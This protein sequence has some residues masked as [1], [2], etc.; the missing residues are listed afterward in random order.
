MCDTDILSLQ[1]W[2]HLYFIR[3]EETSCHCSAVSVRCWFQNTFISCCVWYKEW[4]ESGECALIWELRGALYLHPPWCFICC[5]TL[6]VYLSLTRLR[7]WSWLE[8]TLLSGSHTRTLD[9]ALSL[10]LF[11]CLS[12]YLKLFFPTFSSPSCTLCLHLIPPLSLSPPFFHCH[13]LSVFLSLTLGW[14]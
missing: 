8:L 11:M 12:C 10:S 14:Q 9:S 7:K 5:I 3:L 4:G 13:S 1:L 6:F 2:C